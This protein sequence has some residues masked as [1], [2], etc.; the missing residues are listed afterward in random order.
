MDTNITITDLIAIRNIIN[1][2]AERGAFK[3]EE[4]ADIG[5]TYNKLNKFLEA[6]VAQAAAQEAEKAEKSDT[7][8]ETPQGE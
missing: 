2:A 5:T 6:I 1:A 3:A 4:M 8:A 7:P